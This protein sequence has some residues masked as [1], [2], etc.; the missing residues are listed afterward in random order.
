MLYT[1]SRLTDRVPGAKLRYY[2]FGDQKTHTYTFDCKGGAGDTILIE[3]LDK[4]WTG[5]SISEVKVFG[6]P[7]NCESR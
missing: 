3:D 4:G 2:R 5:H 6:R 7:Y 1:Q